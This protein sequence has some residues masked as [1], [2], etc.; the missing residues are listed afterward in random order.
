MDR[1]HFLRLSATT[2]VGVLFSRLTYGLPAQTPALLG[3][4]A[5]LPGMGPL[6]G[7][8]GQPSGMGPLGGLPG[9]PS[10]MVP[11]D[12]VWVQSGEDWFR[13]EGRDAST[14]GTRDVEVMIK[15]GAVYVQCPTK[16]LNGVRLKWNHHLPAGALFLG[17]AF[18]RSYGDLE[19]KHEPRG[20]KNPWYVVVY[21]DQASACFGVKTGASSICWWE[22]SQDKLALT[23]DTRSGGNGVMLGD[24]TLHMADMV[25]THSHE[26]ENAF[27]TS[28]RFCGIMC[29][30]PR[31]P[32][33]PIYGINDWYFAYG[34]NNYDLIKN[35]TAM[36]AEL[37]TSTDNRPFSVV[38]A[39]WGSILRWI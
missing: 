7:L 12:E 18:E 8:P 1:K 26:G 23:L 11:P 24:R 32:K 5:G 19:W 16:E 29:E 17:D 25:T 6:G 36:M 2:A 37:V 28:H 39:G 3:Q 35:T 4:S 14:F 21:N 13:L 38:D 10:G 34:N 33:K 9:Q 27:A 15:S 30:R 22:L 20:V 31:L